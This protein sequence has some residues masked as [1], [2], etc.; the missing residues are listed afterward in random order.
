MLG[1]VNYL[2]SHPGPFV[3][4][5]GIATVL[6]VVA[7]HGTTL[8]AVEVSSRPAP[9]PSHGGPCPGL[10]AKQFDIFLL[11]CLPILNAGCLTALSASNIVLIPA[12]PSRSAAF[13]ISIKG[14]W[15]RKGA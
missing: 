1:I 14:K 10:H 15:D 9:S 7:V 3:A 12:V 4:L 13:R 11:D 8:T 5:G 2:E 6:G